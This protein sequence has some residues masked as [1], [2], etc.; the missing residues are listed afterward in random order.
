MTK[1]QI[2]ATQKRVGATPDG[3]W[4]PKS[5]AACQ[6]HL[7]SLM[8]SPNP[9]PKSDQ[10]SLTAFYGNAGD[11]SKLVNLDVS[12][13]GVKYGGKAV[14][15]VRCHQ[16][17]AASLHRVF[18]E[19]SKFPEGQKA[20]A[21]Y[22]GVYNNRPMRGGSLPSLHARG[23]AVDLSPATNA[24]KQSWP[25]SATM[26]IE[27]MECFAREGWKSAGAWWSRDAMHSEATQ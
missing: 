9:W 22:A 25:V 26:P 17:V 12:G 2:I 14:R 8:P 16:K 19:L 1:D 7:R 23:A 11:E 18:T 21:E 27:V 10:K 15:T 6:K 4:G 3:F 24:N 13:L 5:I 20:L